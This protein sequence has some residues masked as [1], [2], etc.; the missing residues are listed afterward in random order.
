MRKIMLL[1]LAG[2]LGACS[3]QAKEESV[4]NFTDLISDDQVYLFTLDGCPHCEQAKSYLKRKYPNLKLQARELSDVDYRKYFYACGMK[5]GLNIR[6]LGAPLFCM[7][8]NYI[9]GWDQTDEPRFDEYIK[10]FLKKDNH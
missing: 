1:F 10:P 6:H 8:K 2:M 7:G 3:T 5:F 9:L 4:A